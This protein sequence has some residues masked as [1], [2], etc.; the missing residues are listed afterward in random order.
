MADSLSSLRQHFAT[1]RPP[2]TLNAAYIAAGGATPP[3]EFDDALRRAFR[4]GVA[5]GLT[6]E[7][8]PARVGPVEGDH[9][10]ITNAHLS[11]LGY[12]AAKSDVTLRFRQRLLAVEVLIE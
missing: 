9:F 11:F 8:D 3:A 12:D 1:A 7:F 4:L 10:E 5:P 2:I 6:L